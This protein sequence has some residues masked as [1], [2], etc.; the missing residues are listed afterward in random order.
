MQK[1]KLSLF[2]FLHPVANS[3]GFD[4]FCSSLQY[5]GHYLTHQGCLVHAIGIHRKSITQ[6]EVLAEGEF[7]LFGL[8]G[9][10]GGSPN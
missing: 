1:N 8:C 9:Q 4:M 5:G 2:L 6:C 3:K 10:R 7:K